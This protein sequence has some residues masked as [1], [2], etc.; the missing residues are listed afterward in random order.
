MIDQRT[1]WLTQKPLIT[2]ISVLLLTLCLGWFVQYFKIDASAETLLVKDNK[3][4]I[5]S[6]IMNQRF[7]PDEFILLAY[8]PKQ[9]DVFS[10][11]T[12]EDIQALSKKLKT[13]P[14][15]RSVTHILNVPLLSQMSE[16][17]PKLVAADWTWQSK[18][19]S[20]QQMRQ[21][22]DQHP[23]FTDLLVNQ[24]MSATSIQII[25]KQDPTLIEI[26]TKI[27]NLDKKRLTDQFTEQD[28]TKVEQLKAQ[29][30]PIRQKL[31]KEREQEIEQIYG[32]AAMVKSDA[33]VYLG[34]SY[35]LGHQLINIIRA[36]LKLFGSAIGLAICIMLFVLFR[37]WR[38][39]IIPIA[40]CVTSV[41]MT[42]G[43]FGI[44]DLRTTVI[45]SNFIALQLILTLAICVHLIVQYRQLA[46]DD[47]DASQ[48]QLVSA[49]LRKKIKPCFYA[50]ITTSVGFGSLI[51]SGIQP[52]V[53]FGWM[54][55]IAMFVSIGL[56]LIFLPAL[57][58]LFSR[59]QKAAPNKLSQNFI[60][61]VSVTTLKHSGKV[62]VLFVVVT[63]IAILGLFRLSVEN[64]FLNYFAQDT[65]VHQ[66]LTFIDQQFGG[67][68]PFDI[69]IDI[70]ADMQKTDLALSAKSIQQLQVAQTILKQYPASGNTTS[71]VNF[72]ELAMK[73]NQGRPLT[74][75]ELTAIYRLVDE[76][77]RETLL[78]SYFSIDNQQLRLSS[79]VKDSTEGFNRKEY[80]E[81]LRADLKTNGFTE[82]QYQFT[83]LFVLYQDILQRLFNSQ[84]LT[85]GIVYIAL[86]LV[87]WVLF[88]RLSVALV[89]LVPNVICT[90]VILAVMGYA[91]IP[92]DLMT[93]TIAAIAMGIAVDDTIHFVHHY[94][95]GD[96]KPKEAV[97]QAYFS[98]GY[99]M[100]FT[101]VIICVGFA[102]LAFSD[103]VPSMLFGLLTA[104]AMVVALITDLTLL[105][106]LLTRFITPAVAKP[107]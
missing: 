32:F 103:F 13:L 61:W 49:T 17:D 106:A 81:N 7:S 68:T 46:N 69:I 41:I 18:Q 53:S 58:C 65:Q 92:L 33:N 86:L 25:F 45:S 29:A 19:F 85:L 14:R 20:H 62:I 55:I 36:D 5:Q 6:Q 98:V 79:R 9:H 51:F 75:Y 35:V 88:K 90:L 24:K 64:S 63:G 56:S 76:N 40:C 44:F 80:L 95:H 60:E 48:A 42:M 101:T 50:G 31:N 54:M 87:M 94:L 43:L 12:F 78:G 38:W 91:N 89:A 59:S 67:S 97:K 16:L 104:L 52:V 71:V 70:P 22:F 27:I 107:N 102:L 77:L 3:L 28:A 82:D 23:I 39:V 100:L 47:P 26:E 1:L 34:G 66:E 8:E 11:K 105:P 10:D 93:I 96:S 15:V 74:E 37:S 72:T 73:L 83:N 2:V 4:Y 21:I 57:L 30:D 84:I 99:A